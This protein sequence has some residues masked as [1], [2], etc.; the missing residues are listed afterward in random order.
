MIEKGS[1]RVAIGAYFL[2]LFAIGL[3]K[4]FLK[5]ASDD[6]LGRK[7]EDIGILPKKKVPKSKK[8]K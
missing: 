4:D 8:E 5:L 1:E 6:V 2:V 3:E 7:L